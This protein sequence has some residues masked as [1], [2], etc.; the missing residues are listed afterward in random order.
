MEAEGI[1]KELGLGPETGLR[2]LPFGK[3][4]ISTVGIISGGA[5]FEV[6]E[7]IALGLDAYVTG[8]S[9]HTMYSYCQE[10]R[11]TMICGGHYATEVFG[12]QRVAQDLAKNLGLETA[13]VALPTAL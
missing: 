9:S 2:I 8:E 12:V 7:A 13:F 10:S 3:K 1:A 4:H 6:Q 5:A 11:I